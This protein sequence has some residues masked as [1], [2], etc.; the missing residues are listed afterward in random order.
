MTPLCSQFAVHNLI[1][2]STS[3]TWQLYLRDLDINVR[4]EVCHHVALYLYR[5][6]S[7]GFDLQ[8]REARL[9]ASLERPG[10]KPD[11]D[12]AFSRVQSLQYRREHIH[13]AILALASHRE[14]IKGIKML[15]ARTTPKARLR[16]DK[17]HLAQLGREFDVCASQVTLKHVWAKD[18]L[19][20]A[21][22]AAELVSCPFS[23]QSA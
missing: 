17:L 2:R 4:K 18:M 6:N 11:F 15:I 21:Q 5:M 10:A 16:R 14:I 3:Q 9:D 23:F 22:Q 7:N 1:L 20:R 13:D 12:L 8:S 19:E